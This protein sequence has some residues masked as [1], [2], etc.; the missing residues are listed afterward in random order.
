MKSMRML[1]GTMAALLFG[2]AIA[3]P[4]AVQERNGILASSG[5]H[6]LYVTSDDAPGR[7]TCNGACARAW[8]PYLAREGAQP[9]GALG[10]V[11]R[12]DGSLQW[13][14]AGRPLYFNAA[15]ARPGEVKGD[16]VSGVWSVVRVHGERGAATLMA[17]PV[18][19]TGTPRGRPVL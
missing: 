7:S 16:G 13:A 19:F 18:R 4:A 8:P 10:I 17:V 9:S 2:G 14:H 1:I 12:D 3:A 15:D 6:T 5:G 11:T